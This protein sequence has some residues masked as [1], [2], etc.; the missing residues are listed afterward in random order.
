MTIFVI[1]YTVIITHYRREANLLNT[2]EGLRRQTA[3][4]I[5][6]IVVDMGN[7]I[8][9]LG[10]FP[11]DLKLVDFDLDREFMPLAAARNH[12]A[13][14]SSTEQLIFLD[15]DCVPA[16]DFCEKM[17]EISFRKNG[18]VMG[19]PLYMLGAISESTTPQNLKEQSIF[20]PAR[21]KVNGV[22]KESCYE[23]FW[24]LC[25][26]IPKQR[27]LEMGAFDENY[28]GYGAEDTDFA[29]NTKAAGIPFYLSGAEVYHQQH[30]IYIPPLNHLEPIVNNCNRFHQKWGYW[31]MADCLHDFKTL[32]YIDWNAESKKMIRLM[33]LPNPEQVQERLLKNAPYR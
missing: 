24:S 6:V 18:L 15:V 13:Y 17:A 28:E 10:A 32:G 5:E 8:G 2:L 12:G 29:L 33:R 25:F 31:P 1:H 23:L 4:P 16:E 21:P 30:P 19:T 22:K 3:L 14:Q 27:F 9:S 7:G 11:F 20:H 26:S